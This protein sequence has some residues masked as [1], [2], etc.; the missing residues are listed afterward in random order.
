MSNL[1]EKLKEVEAYLFD[2]EMECYADVVEEAIQELEKSKKKLELE[3][4]LAQEAIEL[5]PLCGNK[6]IGE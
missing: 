5:D 6:K 2:R 4:E 3:I 1:L